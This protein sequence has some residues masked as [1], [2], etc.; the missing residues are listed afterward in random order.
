MET[1]SPQ[2]HSWGD[3]GG[4]VLKQDVQETFALA[5]RRAKEGKPPATPPK[6][7]LQYLVR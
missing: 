2:V 7:I 3:A 6:Q 4:R 5:E 1:L